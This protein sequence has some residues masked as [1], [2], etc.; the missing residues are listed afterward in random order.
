L[1]NKEACRQN[2]TEQL[3]AKFTTKPKAKWMEELV[4]LQKEVQALKL[5]A[6]QSELNQNSADSK[7]V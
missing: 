3:D 1:S 7:Q 6:E 2:T 5:A 4:S